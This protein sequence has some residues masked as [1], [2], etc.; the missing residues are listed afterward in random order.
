MT[1]FRFPR[2]V[3]HARTPP[4][5]D[6]VTIVTHT[7]H[8]GPRSGPFIS[9]QLIGIWDIRATV[10]WRTRRWSRIGSLML[11]EYRSRFDPR[12]WMWRACNEQFRVLEELH[13][14]AMADIDPDIIAAERAA[15]WDATP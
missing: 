14:R 15:G 7:L 6:P 10:M 9:V 12:Y 1:E 2:W 5:S 8:I 4:T 11:H 3:R 13:D